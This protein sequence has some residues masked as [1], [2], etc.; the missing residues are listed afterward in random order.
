MKSLRLSNWK[1]S[2][3]KLKMSWLLLTIGLSLTAL[4][5]VMRTPQKF[6]SDV[7]FCLPRYTEILGELLFS[8]IVMNL[9]AALHIWII[10]AEAEINRLW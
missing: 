2:R 5:K 4:L 9:K 7:F 3:P 8:A 1:F 6:H 10:Y